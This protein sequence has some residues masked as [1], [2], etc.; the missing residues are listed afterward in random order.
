M[1]GIAGIYNLDAA[2][3]LDVQMAH[4]CQ[5]LR[6]RGPDDAGW[7]IHGALGIANTRL[8]IIDLTQSAHQPIFNEDHSVAVVLNGEIYNYRELRTELLARG[9][10]FRSQSDTEVIVH[11]YEEYGSGCIEKLD[12][13]FA[14]ALWD[15]AQRRL[16]LARDRVGKKPLFYYS[17]ASCIVFASEIKALFAHPGVP[18]TINTKALPVLL[19]FGYVPCPRFDL[20]RYSAVG[21]GSWLTIDQNGRLDQ[22]QYWDIRP[23]PR[24]IS[25]QDAREGL[26]RHVESAVQKRLVSDV[27]LGIFLSGGVDSSIIAAVASR[28][29]PTPVRTFTVGF[30]VP[31]TLTSVGMPVW[32]PKDWEPSIKSWS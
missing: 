3:V 26:R 10:I 12:G 25:A 31:P 8:K 29:S 15:A 24:G 23:Q 7:F 9:H 32:S 28:L 17:S 20:F 30:Q 19:A 6:H 5:L 22:Y 13:M 1:C 18:R 14:L 4:M 11:L 21:T 27:P 2:P 16:F